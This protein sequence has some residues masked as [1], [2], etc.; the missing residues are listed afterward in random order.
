M[1]LYKIHSTRGNSLLVFLLTLI[2]V[3]GTGYVIYTN[4]DFQRAHRKQISKLN[5]YL[6]DYKKSAKNF[7][8]K[9]K[10]K[11][12]AWK[13]S[14]PS[15]SNNTSPLKKTETRSFDE[16]IYSQ[17][18]LE[19]ELPA[20]MMRH[21]PDEMTIC[22]FNADFLLNNPLSDKEMVHLANIFRL[23]DLSSIS[24]LSNQQ[25]LS[26]LTTLLKILRYDASFES[27]D[28]SNVDKTVISY[29]YRNDKVQSLKQGK[30]Y[31]GENFFPMSPY[32]KI[33]KVGDFD[34]I[35]AT[36]PSSS[37]GFALTSMEPL[38][39]IYETIKGENSEIK[40]IMIFGNF[41]FQSESLSWD[42]DSLL[43]TF[44]R[45]TS[46]GKNESQLVGNFWFKKN[47]LIEFNGKSGIINISENQFSS[48]QKS[49]LSANRPIWTQFK[50]MS[51]DD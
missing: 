42:S 51:D 45:A 10:E 43:P 29:L 37:E 34:F 36:F 20:E 47:D 30:I 41:T 3:I 40:D 25:F 19:Q 1:F 26:K 9:L 2:I 8:K 6:R 16:L 21:Q 13:K 28:L 33:F 27:S 35:V 23:C 5:F 17:Q 22:A 49:S 18:L 48:R 4:Q 15:K 38:E 39:N 12:A 44:A 24:N 46:A 7:T 14:H 32:Y 50:V 11:I 31:S